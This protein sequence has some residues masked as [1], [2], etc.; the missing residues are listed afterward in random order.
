MAE[1]EKY[2]GLSPEQLKD[3]YAIST[4]HCLICFKETGK[5][6]NKTLYWHESDS[7][8]GCGIFTWCNRC[9]RA[10]TIEEYC[11]QAG[12]SLAEFLKQ[13][14]NMVEAA[15]N[16][17]QKIEWPR[18]FIPLYDTRAKKGVDYLA[19]RNIE[20]DDNIFYDTRR[21]G[22]VFPYYYQDVF[23]G[24]QVRLIKP[25]T[26]GDGIVQ[27]VDTLPG[28]RLGLL[29]YN[30]SQDKLPP[31]IKG[32]I[33]TEGAL[34]ALT[35]QQAI[36]SVYGGTLKSPY[37]VVAC[38]GSGGARHHL[39]TLKEMKDSGYKVIVAPDSNE[40][41]MKMLKKF[42]TAKAATHCV[43]TEDPDR[44]WNDMRKSMSAVEFAQW[45]LQSI[46]K[47]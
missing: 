45:F 43:L 37:R 40:A 19:T 36:A 29:F 39:E 25:W 24:A 1:H 3:L 46:K 17:V 22:I 15:K 12:L 30:W 26:Y 5:F 8:K 47:V 23:C 10:Y 35:I 16:E 33:V 18:D 44:D 2:S 6:R 41:G 21:E 20:P 11:A 28:T 42:L 38:S 32:I 31:N 13:D 34:D 14:F 7:G 27:K 4:E 9:E